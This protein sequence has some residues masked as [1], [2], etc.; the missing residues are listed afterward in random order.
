MRSKFENNPAS[1]SCDTSINENPSIEY[2]ILPVGDHP[3]SVSS[4]STSNDSNLT[5]DI[6]IGNTSGQYKLWYRAVDSNSNRANWTDAAYTLK[7]D[8]VGPNSENV[9][10]TSHRLTITGS[11][12]HLPTFYWQDGLILIL[13]SITI[14]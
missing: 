3:A 7:L 6:Y 9:V 11:T 10:L 1:D 8:L 14:R 5:P 4:F 2:V 13:V 12:K